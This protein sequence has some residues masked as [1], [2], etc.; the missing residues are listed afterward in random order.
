[1]KDS[2]PIGREMSP[3]VKSHILNSRF[4]DACMQLILVS[5]RVMLV[6]LVLL[7]VVSEMLPMVYVPL[8]LSTLTVSDVRQG[9]CEV[10][11]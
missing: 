8:A 1:M 5:A 11:K 2:T 9:I 6:V 10:L 7:Q 3:D 4:L